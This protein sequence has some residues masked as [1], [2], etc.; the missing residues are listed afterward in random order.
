MNGKISV[1]EVR[2][3]YHQFED[4]QGNSYLYPVYVIVA[5]DS[6]DVSNEQFEIIIQAN[7]NK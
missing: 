2:I 6:S 3:E 4:D 5:N 7:Q 1:H